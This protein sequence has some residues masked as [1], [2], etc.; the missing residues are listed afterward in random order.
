L[1][2]VGTL[3]YE[4]GH[5]RIT[6]EAHVVL[7]LK[8]VFGKI[9]QRAHGTISLADTVDTARD[10]E[11][12]LERYPIA[13]ESPVVEQRLRVRA[14]AHK[15]RESLV[16]RILARKAVS[17]GFD[18]A[19]PARDYQKVAAE[20][21]LASGGLLLADDLGV[22]KTVSGICPLT[23]PSTLPCLVVCP[24]GIQRQW[25]RQLARFAPH[26]KTHI[27]KKASPYDLTKLPQAREEQL[28]LGTTPDVIISTYAKLSGWAETLAAFIKYVIYDEAQ[29]LRTGTAS[30]KGAAARAISTR[31]EY[32][33][34]LTGTPI[35]NQGDEM[36]NVMD[37]IR[38]GALGEQHEF[39][40]EWLGGDGRVK[41]PKAFGA[42]LRAEGLMLRRTRQDV[43]RELPPHS[44]VFHHIDSDTAPLND[45]RSAAMALA[46]VILEVGAESARGS[47]FRASEEFNVI[48]R[49]ATG[50]AKG[51]HVA[52]FVRLLVESG[53]PVVLFGWHREVYRIWNERLAEFNPVMVTGSESDKKKDDSVQTFVKG[54]SKVIIVSL[55]SAAGL[56][57]LQFACRTAVH[58]ELD[59]SPGVHE[60]CDCRVFRDGQTQPVVSYYL[61]AEDGSDPFLASILRQKGEQLSGIRD[62]DAEL[63]EKLQTDSTARTRSLAEAYLKLAQVDR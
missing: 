28:M 27:L 59:Y 40:Q 58:G 1:K 50:I 16:Q 6:A 12:F 60:Q 61:Q 45:I 25:R 43:D 8:R 5:F 44:R 33:L 22:G 49:Q 55:R 23:D 47:R 37:C 36:F 2:T 24:K 54:D 56:D 11:W 34:G 18:L 42:F 29:E 17:K 51:P 26:L 35:Y 63:F 10:L 7:R 3:G 57:G 14:S 62:P 31:A 20:L 39:S 15:E 53:E 46:R 41:E 48:L 32:R 9:S 19:E 30:N 21:L 52:D 13:F 38:P 4:D